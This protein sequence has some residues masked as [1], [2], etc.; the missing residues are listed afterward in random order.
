VVGGGADLPAWLQIHMLLMGVRYCAA[1]GTVQLLV[2][3]S[4]CMAVMHRLEWRATGP[5]AVLV[6]QAGTSYIAVALNA[7]PSRGS[8]ASRLEAAAL[9][10]VSVC[11]VRVQ[12][13]C[14]A[15]MKYV[16]HPLAGTTAGRR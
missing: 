16:C 3:C 14:N 12:P 2:L 7:L 6:D 9:L 13:L 4:C 1:A 15:L 5:P 11:T 8:T 10:C